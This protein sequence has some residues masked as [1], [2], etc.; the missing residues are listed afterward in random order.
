MEAGLRSLVIVA[1]ALAL[2][3]AVALAANCGVRAGATVILTSD[4]AD[5][6]V[7]VWDTRE[8]LQAWV[9]GHWSS[10]REVMTHTLIARPGTHAQ[11]VACLGGE[12]RPKLSEAVRDLIGIRIISGPLRGRY[13]W[14]IASD[15]HPTALRAVRAPR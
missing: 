8:R 10:S 12:S 14:V 1:A 2:G 4:P 6:D 9:A 11:V 5:P 7:M 15:V 3:G 13:G